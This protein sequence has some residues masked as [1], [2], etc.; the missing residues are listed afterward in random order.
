MAQVFCDC[1]PILSLNP[2]L[3]SAHFPT[4]IHVCLFDFSNH[5]PCFRTNLYGMC[6]GVYVSITSSSYREVSLQPSGICLPTILRCHCWCLSLPLFTLAPFPLCTSNI[7]Y[8]F[9][10]YNSAKQVFYF[11]V[12]VYGSHFIAS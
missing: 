8:N 9:F 7:V 10:S 12:M 4:Q 3:P 1:G 6:P 11:K 2:L 5:N